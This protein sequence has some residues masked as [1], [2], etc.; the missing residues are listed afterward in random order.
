MPLSGRPARSLCLSELH[1][2]AP[3]RVGWTPVVGQGRS[4]RSPVGGGVRTSASEGGEGAK[5]AGSLSGVS[6]GEVER[7]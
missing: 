4:P 7:R 6:G 2:G 5:V 3:A 1:A